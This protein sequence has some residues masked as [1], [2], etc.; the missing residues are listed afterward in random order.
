MN[1]RLIK[2]LFVCGLLCLNSCA[3]LLMP[4]TD[5]LELESDQDVYVI[6]D[7]DTL[8][9]G[10]EPVALEKRRSREP[11]LFEFVS[12]DSLLPLGT[13]T[14][15]AKRTPVLYLNLFVFWPLIFLDMQSEKSFNYPARLS[16]S[17]A[18]FQTGRTVL[19][20]PK[21][22]KEL[23]FQ[24]NPFRM[25]LYNNKGI[26]FGVEKP[27]NRT[28]SVY[29]SLTLNVPSNENFERRKKQEQKGQKLMVG[30]K[31]YL[32][33]CVGGGFHTGLMF[34]ASQSTYKYNAKMYSIS[35][36]LEVTEEQ[37]FPLRYKEQFLQMA[38][39]IGYAIPLDRRSF[40]DIS[41]G[42]ANRYENIKIAESNDLNGRYPS[43]YSFQKP[44]EG[45][46]SR[47]VFTGAIRFAF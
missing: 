17:P 42:G 2:L 3:T 13:T 43:L 8:L 26:E 34:S 30:A 33:G 28:V 29:S 32:S 11:L 22:G 39:E 9:V 40:I 4:S 35:D 41:I 23:Y 37:H 10:Q 5:T 47:P 21:P 25:L 27:I 20:P 31:K 44:T 1:Q 12:P 19:Q 14:V 45:T 38:L 6:S 16:F 15:K 7:T 24:V 46:V 36:D 18:G